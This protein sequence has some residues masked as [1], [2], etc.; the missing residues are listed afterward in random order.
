MAEGDGALFNN[1]KEVIMNGVFN[2]A[3]AQDAIKVML[4][5]GY[6]PNI[7][8]AH[9]VYADVSA[10][11]YGAGLGYTVTG[12]TLAGQSTAQDDSNDRGAFDGT[13]LTWSA[14]GALSPATPSHAIM[15]DDTPTTPQADPLMAYW[16]LGTTATNGGDYTLQ[17]GANGIILLT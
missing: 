7:D 3:S 9:S 12:E 15:Y 1:L 4:V 5:S 17:W 14:L 6:T 2:L 16:E 8:A 10:N 11:E 13:D